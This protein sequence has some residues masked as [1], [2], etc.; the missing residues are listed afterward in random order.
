MYLM[1]YSSKRFNKFLMS[2]IYIDSRKIIQLKNPAFGT[3]LEQYM[4]LHLKPFLK[5]SLKSVNKAW[6]LSFLRPQFLYLLDILNIYTY[7][8]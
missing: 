2:S 6:T 1:K 7:L 5:L 4:H 8:T 3:S